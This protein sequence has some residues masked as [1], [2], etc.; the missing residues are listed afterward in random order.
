[1]VAFREKYYE[2][3]APTGRG[4]LTVSLSWMIR[5]CYS[6]I[7]EN[8]AL[9]FSCEDVDYIEV[10]TFINVRKTAIGVYCGTKLPPPLMSAENR[11]DVL[12]SNDYS[13]RT[14]QSTGFVFQYKFV[15][16]KSVVRFKMCL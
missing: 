4:A 3:S 2:K 11:L 12:F 16:G 6:T 1:M 7:N 10:D 5:C 9:I 14:D 8:C 15:T 13:S